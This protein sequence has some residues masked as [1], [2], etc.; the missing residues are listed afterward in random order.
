MVSKIFGRGFCCGFKGFWSRVLL[1]RG[2][3]VV[4][5][6]WIEVY[7]LLVI[8]EGCCGFITRGSRFQKMVLRGLFLA[9]Y[10]E[11]GILFSGHHSLVFRLWFSSGVDCLRALL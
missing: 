11:Q 9:T 4:D 7:G 10:V 1:R 3:V 2:W 6:I 5:E 8:E